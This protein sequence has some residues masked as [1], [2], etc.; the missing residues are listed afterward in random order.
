MAE[1]GTAYVS[2]VPSA[3]GFAAK[4]QSELGG[5][6]ARIG[7]TSGD[8]YGRKFSDSARKGVGG[9]A[10]SVFAG[11]AKA[12][13]LVAAAA[14]VA[15]GKVISGALSEARDAAVVGARTE[16]VIKTMGNA[17]N[18]SAD[19]V[20][21]LAGSISN[22]T[23]V[24]DEAIQSGQN[25]LLTFGNVRNEAG[26]GNDVFN[27]TS[28]LMVDMSAA[29]GQDMKGS[30]IQLGKALNDPVKGV[31]ALS[32]VGV[33]FTA[34]Q[35]EQIKA[36]TESG[37]TLGAQKIILGE[38][39]KQFGGAAETMATPAERAKV[40]WGNFQED[41]GTALLP[42][43]DKLLT[44]FSDALPHIISFGKAIGSAVGP[45]IDKIV[46]K[47][48]ALFGA[49]SGG[50]GGGS[51][52]NAVATFRSAFDSIKSIVSSAVTIITRLWALFGDNILRYIRST[53]ANVMQV[54][55]GVFT[56]LKG[57]FNVFAGLLT[58]DWSRMWNGIKQVVSGAKDVLVGIVKQLW[59]V[60]RFAFS[61]AGT[62]VKAIFAGLWN[63]LKRAASAGVSALVG[64]VR[65]IGGKFKGALSS[66][67]STV[68][69]IFANA[70]SA[71]KTA[72][73]NAITT[74]VN[75]VKGIPGKMLALGKDFLSAGKTLIGKF[76]AGLKGAGSLVS[77]IAGNVWNA[78]RG[79]LNNAIDKLNAAL[80]FTIDLP[81]PKNLKVNL[82]NIPHLESGARAMGATLAVIGE[83]REA[84]TVL[85][86]SLLRG[87]LERTHAAGAASGT[88]PVRVFIGDR[89]LTDIV[90]V[91]VDGAQTQQARQLAYGR[92]L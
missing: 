21:K 44:A 40:A 13:P 34:Q 63:L 90:R 32:R 27:Q 3:R 61:N 78:V 50:S 7:S 30:A 38:V 70:F 66:L 74:I 68:R 65:G 76:V 15:V 56:F 35:K 22:K 11:L 87:L 16:N 26:K 2:L 1:V 85:P 64:L 75:A 49:L 77:D 72:V 55:R 31:S 25:L 88:P 84:E 29:M 37:N 62:A 33:S 81:G 4:M 51:V 91:E 42:L 43:V 24:D 39:E 19:Q 79:L 41:I 59:N 8:E 57:I 28:Q 52:G 47:V 89:E 6:I 58:G 83:G 73:T 36:L 67:A 69:G 23:A 48:K 17:A 10:K 20:A 5:D 12:G 14:G 18:I 82:P 92:R 71:G 46:P 86:D 45:V 53:I 54:V 9:R 80:E 60:I